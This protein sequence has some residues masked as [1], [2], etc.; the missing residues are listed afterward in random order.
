MKEVKINE[1]YMRRKARSLLQQGLSYSFILTDLT[2]DLGERTSLAALIVREENEKLA[3]E[4]Q[5]A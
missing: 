2:S 3:K 1:E 5:K 4:V